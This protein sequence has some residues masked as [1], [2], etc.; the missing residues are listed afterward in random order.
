MIG[1]ENMESARIV[2]VAM[3]QQATQGICACSHVLR[4]PAGVFVPPCG[5]RQC[6]KC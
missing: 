5:A 6:P 1:S 4:S 2:I 3:L